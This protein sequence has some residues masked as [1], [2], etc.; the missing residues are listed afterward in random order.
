VVPASGPSAT[1]G[2]CGPSFTT[3]AR[4]HAASAI[5]PL[6]AVRAGRQACFDRLVLEFAGPVD[7]YRV[8][9]VPRVRADGS[10]APVPLTGGARLQLVVDG[11]AHDGAG[12]STFTPRDRARVVDVRGYRAL[13][14][15][16]WAGSFEGATT[17]GVGVR[18]AL[19]F[20]VLVLAGPGT[21]SRV[22]LD[23]AHDG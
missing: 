23:V 11:P 3:A 15:V 21:H 17:L 18:T 20:R 12:R 14:Q 6:V 2:S 5:H 10:G 13:R 8:R 19:P 1:T 16:A 7:G 9:Y 22:V 4:S